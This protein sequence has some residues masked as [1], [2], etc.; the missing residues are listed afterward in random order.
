MIIWLTGLPGVGK[1]RVA[2]ALKAYLE[3]GRRIV[4]L[5]AAEVAS[6]QSEPLEIPVRIQVQ[7]VAWAAQLL[8]QAG[9]VV[10]V[11]SVSPSRE[12]RNSIRHKI[13]DEGIPFFEVW[14]DRKGVTEEQ[15]RKLG[16]EHP[17]PP[18]S[19][20]I[21]GS[22]EEAWALAGRIAFELDL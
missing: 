1:R 7:T 19:R 17:D 8:A 9:T 11:C 2:Q 16:Y 13:L 6:W 15:E 21:T 10:I 5:D 22:G 4:V 12:Q 3:N 18:D 20:V 14:V